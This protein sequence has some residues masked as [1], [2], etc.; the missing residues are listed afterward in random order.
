MNY[1]FVVI[2]IYKLVSNEGDLNNDGA[3]N[4]LD[5]ISLIN[6]VLDN[7]YDSIADL[8]SDNILNVLDIILLVNI[9]LSS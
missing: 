2:N 4:I 9:I 7:N 3:I 6:F 8:N 5:V 1:Y